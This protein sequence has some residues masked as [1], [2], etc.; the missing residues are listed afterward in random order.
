[1][2]ERTTI[3]MHRPENV[4]KVTD[5]F[6]CTT[7][8]LTFTASLYDGK[9]ACFHLGVVRSISRLIHGIAWQMCASK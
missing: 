4:N 1:M 3:E 7:F 6:T 8:H 2:C 9:N 5:V